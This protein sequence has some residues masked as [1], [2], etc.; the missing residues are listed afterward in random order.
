MAKESPGGGGTW[1]YMRSFLGTGKGVMS[2]SILENMRLFV[3]GFLTSD[4]V[5]LASLSYS[6]QGTGG[7]RRK[8]GFS[9]HLWVKIGS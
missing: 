5:R 9:G 7:V 3:G 8:C 6:R 4:L 1:G 2:T